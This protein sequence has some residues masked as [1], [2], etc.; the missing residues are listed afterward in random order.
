VGGFTG[1][2]LP[3]EGIGFRCGVCGRVVGREGQHYGTDGEITA[4]PHANVL[5]VADDWAD[6][7]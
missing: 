7:K 2:T 4:T 6:R 1:N 3:P 5:V